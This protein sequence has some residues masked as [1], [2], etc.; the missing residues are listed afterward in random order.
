MS[1]FK[2]RII[3]SALLMLIFTKSRLIRKLW[4]KRR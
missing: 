2:D 1:S 4:G 3:K